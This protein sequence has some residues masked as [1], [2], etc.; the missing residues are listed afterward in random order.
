MTK[1]TAKFGT[2]VLA[3]VIVSCVINGAANEPEPDEADSPESIS[4]AVTQTEFK[5]VG[6]ASCSAS[7]CHGRRDTTDPTGSEHTAWISEDPHSRAFFTLYSDLS[8]RIATNYRRVIG[9]DDTGAR[10]VKAYEMVVCL[11]C[12]AS[13]PTRDQ[14]AGHHRHTIRDGV[15]CESCHGPAEKW[16]PVHVRFNADQWS[17]NQK[18]GLG[19]HDTANVLTRAKQCVKCHVGS[20]G[21]DVNHDMIAAGHPRLYFELSAYHARMPR[22]WSRRKDLTE[23]G[24]A[25]ESRLWAV[26]QIVSLGAAVDLTAQRAVEAQRMTEDH[27]A[28][29]PEFAGYDCFACHHGLEPDSWRQTQ[30]RRRSRKRTPGTAP[31]G[32]WNTAMFELIAGVEGTQVVS[33][34]NDFR[35]ALET[36]YPDPGRTIALGQA[37]Q[38]RLD[39]LAERVA[40]R[41]FSQR[42]L[43]Q[44]FS[45]LTETHDEIDIET[46]DVAIRFGRQLGG[47]RWEATVQRYLAVVAVFQAASETNSI[48]NNEKTAEL[49]TRLTAIRRELQFMKHLDEG[50]NDTRVQYGSPW[51]YAPKKVMEA[52]RDV[53]LLTP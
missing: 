6:S 30:P 45:V 34:L 13:N 19:F 31:W 8:R 43:N 36:P 9:A 35:R 29:W 49:Q 16:L 7:N 21:R 3:L 47:E 2:S 10:E 32:T 26:G 42:R 53:H 12:H 41:S 38:P 4:V 33:Q 28:A 37:L 51:K 25:L 24:A 23:N 44:L 14:L 1:L 39:D 40:A 18:K 22:H 5:Y 48:A 52:F 17:M 15:G 27:F 50:R 11:N 20:A 46:G